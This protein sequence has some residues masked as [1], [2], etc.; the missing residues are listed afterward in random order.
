M[1]V[2]LLIACVTGCVAVH[3]WTSEDNIQELVLPYHV[4]LKDRTQVVSLVGR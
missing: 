2:Y 4:E 3:V 1:F